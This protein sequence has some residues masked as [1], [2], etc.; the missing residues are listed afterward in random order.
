VYGDFLSH[1]LGFNYLHE[2]AGCGSNWRIWRKITGHVLNKTLVPGDIIVIQYT[3]PER[4]EFY[5]K[6]SPFIH[7]IIDPTNRVK[8]SEAYDAGS[9]I[10]YKHG[11]YQWQDYKDDGR[12]FKEYEDAH[13]NREYDLECFNTQHAMFQEFMKNHNMTVVFINGRYARMN[14]QTLDI[15]DAFKP[16]VFVESKE[17][18]NEEKYFLSPGDLGHLNEAGHER[19]SEML[20]EHFKTINII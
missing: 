4:R 2:G 5:S 11:S 18:M 10:R 17:F 7:P 8:I 15:I 20:Y 3:N 19:F 16:Y 9:I 12:F 13:V 6:N 1:K 14:Y